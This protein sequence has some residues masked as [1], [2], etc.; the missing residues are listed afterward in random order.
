[1]LRS[2]AVALAIDHLANNKPIKLYRDLGSWQPNGQYVKQLSPAIDII[3]VVQRANQQN[4]RQE[5]VG[6]HLEG[7]IRIWTRH[8]LQANNQDAQE[9]GDEIETFETGTPMRPN[10]RYKVYLV[11]SRDEGDFT[12]AWAR[13]ENARGR[14]L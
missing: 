7:V 10:V 1:M 6:E 12:I 11:E 9:G 14:G 5:M 13:A 8:P 3:A 4:A 2:H